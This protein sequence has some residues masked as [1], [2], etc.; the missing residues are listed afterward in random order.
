ML[1]KTTIESLR[2]I[3]ETIILQNLNSVTIAD[4]PDCEPLLFCSMKTAQ[5]TLT[6]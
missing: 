3:M 6:L 2:K 5:A 1:P 4:L